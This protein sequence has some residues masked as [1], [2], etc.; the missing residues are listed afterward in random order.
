MT[1]GACTPGHSIEKCCPNNVCTSRG[2]GFPAQCVEEIG[3]P[4]QHCLGTG[5]PCN[6]GDPMHKCC[7]NNLCDLDNKVCVQVAWKNKNV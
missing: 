3:K 7:P 1:G 5:D 4:E 6:P 2:A